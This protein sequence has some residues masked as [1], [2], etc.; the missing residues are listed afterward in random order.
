MKLRV[1]HSP[2]PGLTEMVELE[3]ADGATVADALLTVD[4]AARWP[5]LSQ[6]SLAVW[7]RRASLDTVLKDGDRVDVLRPLVAD[8]KESRK[9]RYRA[10]PGRQGGIERGRR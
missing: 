4:A 1:A 6:C 7:N 5:A 2:A 10:T 9:Q 3:L 8:P